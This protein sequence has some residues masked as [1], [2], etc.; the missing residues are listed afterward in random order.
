MEVAY[1][2]QGVYN[3]KRVCLDNTDG[4]SDVV[5]SRGESLAYDL[6]KDNL[7]YVKKLES[8]TANNRLFAG[9]SRKDIKILAGE[10]GYFEIDEPGSIT[11]A[12]VLDSG[13]DGMAEYSALRFKYDAA[14]G[15]V[16]YETANAVGCGAAILL[17]AVDGG[18][19]AV[20][21]LKKVYLDTG[22]RQIS[23]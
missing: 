8:A 10:K 16:L 2:E 20:A 4:L 23:A 5:V 7:N 1:I 14:S 22:N 9:V 12:L 17:E 15:G 21:Q 3:P 18:D 11:E 6:S 19:P 13:I